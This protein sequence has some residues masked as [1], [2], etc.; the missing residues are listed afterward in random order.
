[1]LIAK[2]SAFHA[3]AEIRR[4]KR[5]IVSHNGDLILIVVAL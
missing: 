1:M 3:Y 5:V 2:V 4:F